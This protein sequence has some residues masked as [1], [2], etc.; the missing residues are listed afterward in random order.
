MR[1]Y[2]RSTDNVLLRITGQGIDD[3]GEAFILYLNKLSIITGCRYGDIFNMN[4][5][6]DLGRIAG[7]TNP[8]AP[9]SPLT[10]QS[11]RIYISAR[12]NK[13]LFYSVGDFGAELDE[14]QG[15]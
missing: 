3:M 1:C 14:C 8:Y 6:N 9:G 11:S 10:I 13:K 7:I 15:T 4:N 12:I 5:I 2:N